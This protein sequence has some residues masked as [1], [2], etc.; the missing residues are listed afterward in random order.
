MSVQSVTA[1]GAVGDLR[2]VLNLDK[3]VPSPYFRSYWVQQNVTD[4]RAYTAAVSDLF[5]SK[6]EYREEPGS[7]EPLG[8]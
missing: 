3:I 5:R 6:Q 4:M 8:A 2:M 1:A 7:V